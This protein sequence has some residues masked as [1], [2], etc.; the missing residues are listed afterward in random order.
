MGQRRVKFAFLLLVVFAVKSLEINIPEEVKR[1]NLSL[2]DSLENEEV[3]GTGHESRLPTVSSRKHQSVMQSGSGRKLTDRYVTGEMNRSELIN[4]SLDGSKE[5]YTPAEGE[6]PVWFVWDNGICHCG[7]DVDQIVMC[8]SETKQLSVLDCHCLTEHHTAEGAVFPVVGGCIFNCVNHSRISKYGTIYHIAPSN[9]AMLNRQGTLCG[10][11]IEGYVVAAYSYK[12]ECV[13]C[14]NK[15]GLY[16]VFAFF[17]LTIFIIVILA[18]RINALDPRLYT[19]VFAAQ[20]ISAPAFLKII[21][22]YLALRDMPQFGMI[23]TEITLTFYGIWNLDFLRVNVLPDI[24]INA[25]PLHILVLDY[26][27]A[28]YPMLLLAITYTVAQLYSYGFRPILYLWRPFHHFF[29][30]F[31]RQWGI[32]STIMDAFVT[33]FIL[34][35]TKLFSVSF[36]LLIATRVFTQDGKLYSKNL[37]Y[38]PSIKY[39]GKEHL[40]Y[41]VLALG[42][43]ATFIVFPTSL[44]LC[45][46][47]KPYKK[48]LE[49]C[50][51]CGDTVDAFVD[52]FQKYYRDGS[53]GGI[54]CRWFAG[55]FILYKSVCYLIYSVSLNDTSFSL[56]TMSAIIAAIVVFIVEPYKEEYSEFNIISTNLFL[57]IALF[58]AFMMRETM[59]SIL[60]VEFRDHYIS[61]FILWLLPIAYIFGAVLVPIFRRLWRNRRN[62]SM[63]SSLPHRLL[64]SDQYKDTFGYIAAQRD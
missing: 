9:C 61:T 57:W 12:F 11:C 37:Y 4:I 21:L 42:I 35:T 43:V 33:F 52:T 48:C 25:I 28:I 30:R 45:Y 19:F 36:D 59:S 27:V 49:K 7:S 17:P 56:F 62:V 44:L 47:C 20:I 31:R 13:K 8:D 63:T 14:D 41:A 23:A 6:C 5:N 24:C 50:R 64:H 3:H 34:S 22:Y 53:N 1:H 54:D 2:K 18:F 60:Q 51:I 32:E 10:E 39:F 16:I 40:P 55:F 58:S 38:D 46:Q 15:W 26:L 29:A